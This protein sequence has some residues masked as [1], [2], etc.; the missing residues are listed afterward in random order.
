MIRRMQRA[1]ID[2]VADIWLDTNIRAHNFISK[3]YWQNN[4]SIVKEMLSQSEI[5][6]YEEKN[7]IQ[8]FVGLSD[9]YIEGIFVSSKE[10]SK[11]IG[12]LLMCYVKNIKNQLSLSVYQ[13]NIRAVNFYQKE[14]FNIQSENVDENT[15]EKAGS[16]CEALVDQLKQS[17][18]DEVYAVK[19]DRDCAFQDDALSQVIADML[20]KIDPS[21]VLVPATP[22]GRSIFSRVAVKL[23]C[24]L[25]ADCTELLVAKREDGTYYIKQNK[26]SFGENVFVTIVT[27][28]GYYPQMMTVRPGVYTPYEGEGSA[29]VT[30]FDDIALPASKIEVVGAV[31]AEAETDSI[32]AAEVVVVGGRGA[33]EPESFA[34]LKAFADK[35]GAAIGGTRPLADTG[36]IPFQNQ[37][38]QTGFT[39]RPKICISLGVSGAIQHTEGIKDTKLMVAINTDENAPIYNIADYGMTADLNEV[40]KAYLEL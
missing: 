38:G 5:Y 24:G 12:N 30:Y 29:E 28:E 17:G 26:P 16:E 10:Q 40:L 25:T 21:S 23:N 7:E 14:D 4:F 11:G 20:K 13:K 3:Q 36:Q 32:L 39:I 27:K 1:D 15:G 8:G 34:L 31:P 37:I 18:A 6:V 2:R 22:M 35:I 9:K 33:E 19:T